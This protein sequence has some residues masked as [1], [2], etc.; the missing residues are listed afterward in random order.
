MKPPKR[1]YEKIKTD[2]FVQ[3]QIE[4]ITYDLEHE[5]VYKDQK[6]IKPAVRFKFLI[7]GYKEY[8]YS[9]WMTFNYGEKSNLFKKYVTALV[10]GALPNMDFDLDKLKGMNIKMLWKD[11]KNGYQSIDVIRPLTNKLVGVT[12]QPPQMEEV[13]EEE[14]PF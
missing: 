11:E 13:S 7:E 5:F 1:E 2:E 4:D 12:A 6:N 8:H 14:V 9:R 10:E 3:G